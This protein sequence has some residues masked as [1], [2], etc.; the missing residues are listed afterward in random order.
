MIIIPCCI[1][2]VNNDTDLCETSLPPLSSIP[3]DAEAAGYR[4]AEALDGLMK[5]HRPPK[6]EIRYKPLPVVVR[7][8]SANTQTDDPPVTVNHPVNDDS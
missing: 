5:G 8:S 2:T 4:A 7:A 3:L 6:R 1:L